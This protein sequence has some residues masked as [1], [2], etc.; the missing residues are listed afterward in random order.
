MVSPVVSKAKRKLKESTDAAN[1]RRAEQK[2]VKRRA[3]SSEPVLC[4]THDEFP[5]T[6]PMCRSR[7]TK[8]LPETPGGVLAWRCMKC[9]AV[10]HGDRV[11]LRDRYEGAK[12]SP[13]RRTKYD[14]DRYAD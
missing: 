12:P 14:S 3:A 10:G 11:I 9:L 7:K 13:G 8:P 6:C 2:P 4:M 1:K 5:K